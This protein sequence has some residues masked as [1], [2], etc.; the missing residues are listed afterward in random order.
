LPTIYLVFLSLSN[1]D[2][3]PLDQLAGIEIGIM[4]GQPLFSQERRC[5]VSGVCR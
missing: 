1:P 2:F 3:M 5:I 4:I